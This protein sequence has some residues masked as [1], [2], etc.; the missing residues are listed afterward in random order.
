MYHLEE[1]RQFYQG[2]RV[3]VTGHTGFKGT[4]LCRIL[5]LAGAK[6][7]GYSL[8]PPTDPSL[9]QIAGLEDLMDSRIGDIRDRNHLMQVFQEVSPELV[10]HLA[11]QPIVRDSYKDPVYT[12]ET[13]VMGTVNL[14]ECVRLFPCVRSV[15]NVT[16]DKVYENREWEYGYRECDPLDGY[17]P[18]S[19]SKSCSELVTHSY[20][21]SFFQNNPC[22][23]STA[24]AGNVIG[25]GD[26]ANDRIIPDCVRAMGRKQEIV[27]RNPASIRPYQ[28]VLEP[29]FV[30]LQIV[31]RQ[32]E[33]R[34]VEGYYNVGPDDCDCVT[35]GQLATV[36]CELWG[37]EARWVSQ[38]D[39]GP[40]EANFLKLD[41]SK[42]KHVLGWRPR[43]NIREALELTV[44]WS[45]AYLEGE[46]ILAVMDRQIGS[47]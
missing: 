33:D 46:E 5:T 31:Q 16:T 2:R 43:W 38:G 6:V 27:V 12:Y 29:L 11:A 18:Y 10:F 19:N 25:G 22:A 9:F 8:K 30:Y 39:G 47:Y 15:L 42:L 3:L 41:C 21:K 45:K 20:K 1:C 36:F 34:T 35:T 26:F 37:Q 28:H 4:W 17:D 13:N 23:V 32:Y 44:E 40:H 14:L 24:R 7:T